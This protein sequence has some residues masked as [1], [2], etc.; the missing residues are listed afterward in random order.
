MRHL[1]SDDK[2]FLTTIYGNIREGYLR[3]MRQCDAFPAEGDMLA[4]AFGH[5]GKIRLGNALG[6][7]TPLTEVRSVEGLPEAATGKYNLIAAYYVVESLDDEELP[8][9]FHHIMGLLLAGGSLMVVE[10][11]DNGGATLKRL[12]KACT[13]QGLSEVATELWRTEPLNTWDRRG[14]AGRPLKGL[15]KHLPLLWRMRAR[16]A[17]VLFT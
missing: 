3:R 5:D 11:L 17:S 16:A 15:V 8:L 4:V 1:H 12:R 7:M 10:R 9:F 6:H 13:E 14:N 2:L